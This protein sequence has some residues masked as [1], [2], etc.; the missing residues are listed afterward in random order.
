ML[1]RDS[2]QKQDKPKQQQDTSKKKRSPSD[3]SSIHDDCT[4]YW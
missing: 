3:I 2:K 4:L 1:N